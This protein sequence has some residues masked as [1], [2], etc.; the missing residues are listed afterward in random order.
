MPPRHILIVN[1]RNVS[2][3]VFVIGAPHSGAES[4]GRALKISPG[5]H[6]T[7]GRQAVLQAVYGFA[8]RPSLYA[9][10][11]DA[12]AAVMRDAFAQG[13]QIG[14]T[15]CLECTPQC[16]S[17]AGLRASEVGPCA[18]VR[19]LERFGDASPDLA[20]CAE[21]LIAAFPDA[22]IIQVVRDGRDTVAAMLADQVAMSWFRPSVV[23]IET[24]FPNPFYGVEDESDRLAWPG[25]SPSGKCAL[26]WRGAIRLAARL[27]R[28]LPDGQLKT[29][30]YEDVARDPGG[31][32]SALTDFT[33]TKIAAPVTPTTKRAR[34]EQN[35]W[36]RSLSFSQLAE[37]EKIAGEELRKLGYK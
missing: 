7:I 10:R 26:R 2:Q 25:L 8:R 6:V 5:F 11:G 30:R 3:P 36:R 23:N 22:L 1:S 16:R 14:S 19:G 35:A 37:I 34:T 24:E 28:S 32:A 17:A 33:G 20:Y 13:W 18:E 9:G 27:R 15:S 21:A 4:V 12:A 31:A 29:L